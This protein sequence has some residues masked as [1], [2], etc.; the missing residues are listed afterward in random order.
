MSYNN[1]Q[2]NT[3]QNVLINYEP[4]GIFERGVSYLIDILV[5][6]IYAL[7]VQIICVTVKSGSI[8]TGDS[9]YIWTVVL[10][11]LFSLPLMLYSLLC[12]V[13][14]SGQSFGKKIMAIKVIKLNG[15]Q[16]SL[17]AYLLRWLFRLIDLYLMSPLTPIV[18]LISILATK[19]SQ[20]LGD[21]SAGTTVIKTTSRASL[22]HT[23][24]YKANTGNKITFLEV[25]KLND[26][27]IAIIKEVYQQCRQHK[28]YTLFLKLVEKVKK[29]MGLET[30]NM[31]PEEFINTVLLD[32]TQFEFDA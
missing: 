26:R 6:L 20:R 4:A 29:Q 19:N 8:K 21:I 31:T 32:Y 9:Y 10:Y 7:I 17:S 1:I 16:P 14:M 15:T 12:E 13:F 5:L 18:G 24:L 25:E 11:T 28:D 30:I 23:I 27:D 22:H 3:T 2:I